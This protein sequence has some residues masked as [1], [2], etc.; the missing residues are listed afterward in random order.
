MA[1]RRGFD[2]RVSSLDSYDLE[3]LPNTY[4]A[5][6]IVSTTGDGEVPSNMKKFW[7]SLPMDS[8]AG[9]RF[10]VFGLGDSSYIKYNAAA[11]KLHARLLQLGSTELVPRGLGDDQSPR[12]MWGDLDPWL[13]LLWTKLLNLCPLPSG[14]EPDDTPQLS[15]PLYSVN[16]V[17]GGESGVFDVALQAE[18]E[19]GRREFLASVAPPGGMDASSTP[20]RAQLSHLLVNQRITAPDHFQDVRHL[21]LQ[22]EAGHTPPDKSGSEEATTLYKAGDVAWVQPKNTAESVETLAEM[23][24][25]NLNQVLRITPVHSTPSSDG[26]GL[27]TEGCA[28]V[29]APPFPPIVCSVG[30]LFSCHLD[31][32]GTPR[33]G[34]FERLSVFACDPDESE[35]LLELASPGGADL[36]YE[37][38]TR[39]KRTY[40]EVLQDFPSCL[41][42]ALE[43]IIE[44]VPRL[45]PRAF[46]IAS[47][48]LETPGKVQLCVAVV[49][50]R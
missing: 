48:H 47:S 35:K 36:L 44:I 24:C 42:L 1:R 20:V 40:V 46:S 14:I 18:M 34:F 9:M 38:A 21:E 17:A 4:M 2:V 28:P 11:R 8:L 12:G 6:F 31:I 50:F 22:M 23:L 27:A 7:Q 10:G 29:P 45:R 13:S 32:L 39:E 37:Y 26:V 41:P 5:V 43:R 33:R 16:I 3:K 49:S 30:D 15:P 19:H 25:L